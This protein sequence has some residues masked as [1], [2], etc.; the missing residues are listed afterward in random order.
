M[1][2]GG[3]TP[4]PRAPLPS[5]TNIHAIVRMSAYSRCLADPTAEIQIP[6]ALLKS[7]RQGEGDQTPPRAPLASVTNTH[8]VI[9]MS[10]CSRCL[11][12]LTV[13]IQIPLAFPYSKL[14]LGR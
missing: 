12:D 5:V 2:E 14:M 13:E 3:L 10:A 4:P 9:R 8:S 6:L 1:G 7:K 11:A